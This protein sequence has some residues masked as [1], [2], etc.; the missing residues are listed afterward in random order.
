MIKKY[1]LIDHTHN[2]KAVKLDRMYRTAAQIALKYG[3]MGDGALNYNQ[4]R[5]CEF[6]KYEEN[7]PCFHTFSS[8]VR[9]PSIKWYIHNEITVNE[10]IWTPDFLRGLTSHCDIKWNKNK[11]PS[12]LWY[13][14]Q[15]IANL[16]RSCP[17]GGEVFDQDKEGYDYR[18]NGVPAL[19]LKYSDKSIQF[20]AGL[21]AG[22]KI[23]DVNGYKYACCGYRVLKYLK[24]WGIPVEGKYFNRAYL[25]SPIWPA[26]FIKYM[27]IEESKKWL[28]IKK[29]FNVNIYAPILW[30]TYINNQ[31]IVDGIP[32]LKARRSIY[33]EFKCEEGA[34]HKL[35]MLR[36]S[37]ALTELDNRVRQV[38]KEWSDAAKQEVSCISVGSEL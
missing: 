37:K 30:K 23:V 21:M 28:D 22:F 15:D 17:Y 11:F 34:M 24:E 5:I 32:Y 36:V 26:L 6:W 13:C 19:Y 7:Y 16:L 8:Q 10:K 4:D 1:H 14:N 20:M 9:L 3:C 31:F 38:V 33:Y 25:I 12:C 27:P 2:K 29:A 35:D 18:W